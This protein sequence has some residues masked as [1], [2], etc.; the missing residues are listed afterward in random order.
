MSAPGR[1]PLVV[2]NW[3]M[4]LGESGA[5]HLLDDLL[6]RLETVPEVDTAVAPAF[7]VLRAAGDRLHGTATALAAQD[8]HWEEQGAF[9]GEVA[10]GMLAELGVRY[11]IV[12][13]SERRALFGETDDAVRRKVLA[14]R[15][16]GIVPVACVGESEVE[17]DE[18]RTLATVERQVRRALGDLTNV[19]GD[20]V[21]VAYE[22]VWAIGTGRTPAPDQ[23][24]EVHRMIREQLA[25]LLGAA[26]AERVRIL[27]GGSV[28]PDNA[29]SLLTLPEVDGGLVGG[30]SLDAV[31]FAAIVAAA[32]P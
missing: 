5:R 24:H 15:R 4:H 11:G 31:R 7:P 20:D 25:A 19:D 28:T 6:P 17:R 14:L 18:G 23:V 29:G 13:H 12:G 30:A 22:P 2:A 32:R 10:P 9:T 21:V 16:H 1:T 3:K 8:V 27:Y 26:A